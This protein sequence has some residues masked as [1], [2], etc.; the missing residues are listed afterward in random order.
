MTPR[1]KL[2]YVALL[3]CGH[4]KQS[5]VNFRD[6]TYCLTCQRMV[7]VNSKYAVYRVRCVS[8]TYS[9]QF[10]AGRLKAQ[11][12][13]DKHARAHPGHHLRVYAG[14]RL[15]EDRVPQTQAQLETERPPY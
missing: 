7:K 9:R 5:Y 10:G 13:A 12:A 14:A 1:V 6:E 8:C 3:S 11:L 2:N 15:L 4:G